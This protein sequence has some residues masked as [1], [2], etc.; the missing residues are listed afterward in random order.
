MTKTSE[1]VRNMAAD[2]VSQIRAGWVI[3]SGD[4]YV[5]ISACQKAYPHHDRYGIELGLEEFVNG[6]ASLMGDNLAKLY[7]L[8]CRNAGI[9]DDPQIFWMA[10]WTK[11]IRDIGGPDHRELLTNRKY[12]H[13][14]IAEALA[15]SQEFA[16]SFIKAMKADLHVDA[17]EE[18][19]QYLASYTIPEREPIVTELRRGLG[20]YRKNSS[21][22]KQAKAIVDSLQIT[23]DMMLPAAATPAPRGP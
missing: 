13:A 22:P 23:L 6:I 18:L 1:A 10:I 8:E 2:L 16:P 17:A 21:K 5:Q 11:Q 15:F 12:S 19:R 9:I 20:S 4:Q 14:D 3:I 7:H